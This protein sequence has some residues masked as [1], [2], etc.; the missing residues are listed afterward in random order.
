VYKTKYAVYGS[1][2]K[3]KERL[4][5]KGFAQH[6]SIY[7]NETYALVAR[8]NKIRT[9]LALETQYKWLVY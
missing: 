1:I 9:V 4:V 7:Y 2:Q 8:L 3:N 5:A 6:P